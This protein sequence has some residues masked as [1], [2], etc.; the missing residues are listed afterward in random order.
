M[1][2]FE[3]ER[4]MDNQKPQRDLY[5]VDPELLEV[6]EQS[7]LAGANTQVSSKKIKPLKAVDTPPTAT[8]AT[9]DTAID[10]TL[11][12]DSESAAADV[13]PQAAADYVPESESKPEPQVE[14]NIDVETLDEP[15]IEEAPLAEA[16]ADAV[17]MALDEPEIEEA[18]LTEAEPEAEAEAF[19]V[20]LDEPEIE[21]AASEEE[22]E[23]LEPSS[24]PEIESETES[25]L[26]SEPESATIAMPELKSEAEAEVTPEKAA[27]TNTE[28]NQQTHDGANIDKLFAEVSAEYE[29]IQTMIKKAQESQDID[30]P[31]EPDDDDIDLTQIAIPEEDSGLSAP[32]SVNPVTETTSNN[33]FDIVDAHQ[34]ETDE[35]DTSDSLLLPE[36]FGETVAAVSAPAGLSLT[37]NI[38]VL[39][40]LS[41]T[42]RAHTAALEEL[43]LAEQNANSLTDT[44]E[45]HRDVVANYD[46]IVAAQQA[47][48]MDANTALEAAT[49]EK[50]LNESH[51]EQGQAFL[52]KL[53]ASN[54]QEIAPYLDLAES[55][56]NALDDAERIYQD[57]AHSLQI[58]TAQANDAINSHDIQVSNA[59]NAINRAESRLAQLQDEYAA[60]KSSPETGAKELSDKNGDVARALAQLDNARAKALQI[61]EESSYSVNNAQALLANQQRFFSDSET[62]L[63]SA[64][65]DEQM[66]HERYISMRSNADA[67][68]QDIA[69]RIQE[70]VEDIKQSMVKQTDAQK[71]VDAAQA[72]L[73]DANNIR[74]NPDA[75]EQ[76]AADADSAQQIY[77]HKLS[78]VNQLAETKDSL[79]A[80]AKQ[81][82]LVLGGF[83]AIL[84]VVICLVIWFI[85]NR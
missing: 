73:D 58:A 85:F 10:A 30:I 26:A 62:M 61:E 18:P 59:T 68:E 67:Q 27:T 28:P 71:R 25:A 78:E 60:M 65:A 7:P 24:E 80:M 70:I 14:A 77:Q 75:T 39:R 72:I 13:A 50:E 48:L 40:Q 45:H 11:E 17:P 2:I 53:K 63:R 9:E 43:S 81:A 52:E 33:V 76:L 32:E 64:Q 20:P 54:E 74:N 22:V 56:K 1:V 57:A 8:Q 36:Q 66:K 23:E 35:V 19:P 44:L 3:S 49:Q 29:A 31:P 4:Y 46:E 69:E 42:K 41:Q 83:A 12:M 84:I 37:G 38:N 21:P 15:D 55:S 5:I 79:Q 47:E 16:E 82:Y 6:I 51:Y 34:E